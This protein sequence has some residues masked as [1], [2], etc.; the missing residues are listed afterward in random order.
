MVF[1]GLLGFE[2]TK[3]M[4]TVHECPLPFN[5]LATCPLFMGL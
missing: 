5:V 4:G 2:D 3:P 1:K